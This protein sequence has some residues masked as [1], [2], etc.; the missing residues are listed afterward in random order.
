MW[1][2]TA[3][4]EILFETRLVY[5]PGRRSA[6]KPMAPATLC[7]FAGATMQI[8]NFAAALSPGRPSRATPGR[9]P[10]A[11]PWGKYH[12]PRRNAASCCTRLCSP[13]CH[14]LSS[15]HAGMLSP[16]PHQFEGDPAQLKTN[17]NVNGV[18]G[19]LLLVSVVV[20]IWLL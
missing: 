19:R 14:L 7:S 4:E 10:P 13:W 3:M 9:C 18:H 2:L 17:P 20:G 1:F 8:D 15:H 16:P 11:E 12:Q 6:E 5:S